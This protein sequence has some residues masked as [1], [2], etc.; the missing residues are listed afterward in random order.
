[1]MLQL[2]P[3]IP[4]QTPKGKG[5][6]IMVI[7][8]SQE[9]DLVWVVADDCTGEIWL[10]KNSEIRFQTNL[11]FGRVVSSSDLRSKPGSP[12]TED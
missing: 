12:S 5:M 8:Y 7:D 11:T 6:G 2:D 4:L 10:W 1:M 3:M 9:H